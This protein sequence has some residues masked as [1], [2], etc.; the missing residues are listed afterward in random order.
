MYQETR[1]DITSAVLL[2]QVCLLKQPHVKVGEVPR[3]Q[4]TPQRALIT[5]EPVRHI[6]NH[7]LGSCARAD[8]TQVATACL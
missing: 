5:L 1:L 2:I 8:G 3:C 7:L 4:H 6:F